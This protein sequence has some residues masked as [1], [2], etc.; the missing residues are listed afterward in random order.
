[1]DMFEDT[2]TS[3]NAPE[4]TVSELSGAI[5]KVIEGRCRS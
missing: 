3:S 2:R 4:F 5:K 1:M